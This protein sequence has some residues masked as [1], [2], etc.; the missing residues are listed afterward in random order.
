MGMR[1]IVIE[2]DLDL[3]VNESVWGGQRNGLYGMVLKRYELGFCKDDILRIEGV[4]I[5]FLIG[6]ET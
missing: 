2:M 4:G 1:F 5:Q 6:H 3:W